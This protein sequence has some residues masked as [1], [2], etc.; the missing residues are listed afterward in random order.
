MA[1]STSITSMNN[2]YGSNK[3]DIKFKGKSNTE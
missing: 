3:M 1:T 2:N